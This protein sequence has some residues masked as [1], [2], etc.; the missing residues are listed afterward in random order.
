MSEREREQFGEQMR[1]QNFFVVF[2]SGT[3]ELEVSSG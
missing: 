2:S 1:V 3:G